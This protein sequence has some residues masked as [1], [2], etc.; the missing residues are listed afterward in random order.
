MTINQFIKHIENLVG[1]VCFEYRSKP[2]GID[3]LSRN[4]YEMWYGKE[5]FTASTVDEVM[6]VKFYDG[7][8]LTAIWDDIT[9]LEY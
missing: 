7:K 2:C 1:C 8:S 4:K 3:P 5:C 6:T 9:D